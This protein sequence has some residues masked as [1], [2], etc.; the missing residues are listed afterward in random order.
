[1]NNWPNLRELRERE[2]A[3][4]WSSRWRGPLDRQA[5]RLMKKL[6]DQ[7]AVVFLDRYAASRIIMAELFDAIAVGAVVGLNIYVV[8][9]LILIR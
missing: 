4:R 1:M 5:S 9:T 3:R 6:E 2:K 8:M 7:K